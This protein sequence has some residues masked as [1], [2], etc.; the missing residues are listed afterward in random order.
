VEADLREGR[1]LCVVA[2]NALE[3][4]ID[5]GE[6]DA[7]IC[8]GYP[9]SI[10]ATWQRFGRAGRRGG[11]SIAVMCA[12]STALDQYLAQ[13]PDYLLRGEIEEAR[14]D[15][16]NTEILIQHLK[17]AAFELPFLRGED[18][19]GMDPE[20]TEQALQ[21][22]ARHGVVHESEDRFH[23]STDAYPANHVS[24]RT[25]GW[26]NFVIIDRVEGKVLAELDWRST[27]T[28]LHEQAIYQHDA[29]QY[30][31][32]RLD[33]D[34]HKAYVRKVRPDYFTTALT[35]RTVEVIEAAAAAGLG[36]LSLG[37]GDVKV[38][39][40][41]TGYKKIKFF[42]HENA[43][44]GDV[45]LPEMQM[46]TT[47][48]WMTVPESLLA[49][50]EAPRPAVID[51]LRGIGAAL[52]TVS[53]LA[54]MC[55]PSDLG[56]TLGDG[57]TDAC[58]ATR[59]DRERMPG[60]APCPPGRNPHAGRTGGFDPTLFL[61]DTVPGGVGLAQRIFERAGELLGAADALIT[62]CPCEAGC[63]ACVLPAEEAGRKALAARILRRLLGTP[64]TERAG[65][66]AQ[67]P[68]PSAG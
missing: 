32:E 33:Y 52:E 47:A 64:A 51:A 31:V 65:A 29:E 66:A 1:I 40:K 67:V 54:L 59:G 10:A 8:A 56:R 15:P 13:N 18:Y 21:F 39:E 44:Y 37:W 17:C 63:P 5:I 14:I 26:D 49:S 41:V 12:N 24:L 53:T 55:E 16:E 30:Q 19:R 25:V 2:T 62:G 9:G 58:R 23:W 7:V 4:G 27:H 11:T 6:L 35:Y 45:H 28:M 3:L 38:I 48:F 68:A 46:H 43:G 20:S 36:P 57:E 22:L 60:E 34:D 50:L 61:F 42:T